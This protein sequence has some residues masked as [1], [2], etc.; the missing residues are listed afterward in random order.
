MNE[1]YPQHII[2][3]TGATSGIGAQAI[4]QLA[5]SSDTLVLTG[6]RGNGR[7]G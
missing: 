7:G 3:M 4:K 5:A 2:V 6:A 1:T